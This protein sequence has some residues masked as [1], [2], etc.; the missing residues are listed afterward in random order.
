MRPALKSIFMRIQDMT[1][2]TSEVFQALLSDK[3]SYW[4]KTG[5]SMTI[6]DDDIDIKSEEIM[7]GG[8]L[9]DIV[10]LINEFELSFY[11]TCKAMSIVVRIY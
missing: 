11:I 2:Q 9:I 10:G 5:C 3:L 1:P 6:S 7:Y 4:L 8:V